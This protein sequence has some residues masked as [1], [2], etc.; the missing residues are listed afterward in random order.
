MYISGRPR[1][2]LG[3]GV[4]SRGRESVD[5]TVIGK[6][7]S[8]TA[9]ML[10]VNVYSCRVTASAALISHL[11]LYV[12]VFLL[13]CNPLVPSPLLSL[14]RVASRRVEGIDGLPL[15]ARDRGHERYPNRAGRWGPES[16][17]SES[18]RRS[19]PLGTKTC[20]S[21]PVFRILSTIDIMR[22]CMHRA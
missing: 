13:L 9:I 17:R 21:K 11:S 3:P 14:G 12:C 18:G 2:S 7:R 5:L 15:R 1:L 20:V 19:A 6:W 22:P 16:R 8:F 4:P 10:T